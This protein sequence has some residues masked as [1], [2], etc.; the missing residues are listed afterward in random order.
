MSSIKTYPKKRLSIIIETP[1][2]KRLRHIL[3]ELEVPGYTV[4][5]ALAGNGKSGSWNRD[6]QSSDAGTMVQVLIVLDES[7]VEEVLKA[8]HAVL[9]RQ[10]GI[11]SLSDIEVLR[12]ELF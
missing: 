11:V 2:L 9:E 7:L 12:P 8:V 1:F 3:D 10:I 4:L 6:T 5:P